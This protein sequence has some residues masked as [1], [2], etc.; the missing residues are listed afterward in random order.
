[1]PSPGNFCAH[2]K[3]RTAKPLAKGPT[4]LGQANHTGGESAGIADFPHSGKA[5]RFR[6]SPKP[7]AQLTVNTHKDQNVIVNDGSRR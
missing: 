4:G 7:P 3:T 2:D 6:G 5:F 1:M